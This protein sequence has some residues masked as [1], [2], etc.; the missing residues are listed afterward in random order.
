[1][2]TPKAP[3]AVIAMNPNPINSPR[4]FICI[5]IYFASV[6]A[7]PSKGLVLAQVDFFHGTAIAQ[8]C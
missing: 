5:F 4:V 8:F 3:M 2:D 1:M 7:V 6:L